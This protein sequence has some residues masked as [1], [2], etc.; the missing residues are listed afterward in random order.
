MSPTAAG[1]HD[2]VGLDRTLERLPHEQWLRA[3]GASRFAFRTDSNLA[4]EHAVVSGMGIGL[5]SEAQGGA[6]E[7]LVQLDLDDS[8]P[9]VELLVQQVSVRLRGSFVDGH[10]SRRI[11]SQPSA[12]RTPSDANL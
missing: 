3:Y 5:L 2:W 1:A 10:A 9:P 6:L 7:S 12:S 8:P 11:A 4:I